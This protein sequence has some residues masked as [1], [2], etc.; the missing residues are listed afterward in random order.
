MGVASLLAAVTV[1]W[2]PDGPSLMSSLSLHASRLLPLWIALAAG[3]AG[4][5]TWAIVRRTK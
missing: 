1:A 5:A 2:P 4:L 3:T